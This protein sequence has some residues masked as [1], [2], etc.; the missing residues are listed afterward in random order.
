[1]G[2]SFH[3][4]SDRYGRD[5]GT[6]TRDEFEHMCLECFGSAPVLVE[7]IDGWHDADGLVLQRIDQDAQNTHN[8]LCNALN[9]AIATSIANNRI[10]T[11]EV[12][13]LDAALAEL[14][15]RTDYHTDHAVENDGSLD[16]WGWTDTTRE[17]TQ[18]WRLRLVRCAV[19]V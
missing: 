19:G 1:M 3:Y 14:E 11:V 16:V 10:V 8:A 5:P 17:N 9:N 18:D 4:V 15:D 7:H 2:T 13:D 12:A 6:Y